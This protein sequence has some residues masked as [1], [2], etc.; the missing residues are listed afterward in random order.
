MRIPENEKALPLVEAVQKATGRRPHLSTVVRW[1]QR[2]NRHGI[3]LESWLIGG[4]RVTSVERV[5]A[6]NE[7]TTAAADHGISEATALRRPA[8]H[9]AA[10]H[11]LD[12][13]YS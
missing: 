6:Y 13:E 11:D 8:A 9:A 4:R 3:R 5:R 7:R 1:C 2:S 10:V 12:R